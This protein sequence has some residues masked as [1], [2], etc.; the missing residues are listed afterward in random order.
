MSFNE[1]IFM[2]K[3]DNVTEMTQLRLVGYRHVIG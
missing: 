3:M 2:N 1:L